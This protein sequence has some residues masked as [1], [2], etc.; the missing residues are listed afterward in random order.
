MSPDTSTISPD[1]GSMQARS[2]LAAWAGLQAGAEGPAA[3]ET[4]WLQALHAVELCQQVAE[5]AARCGCS[6]K[7]PVSALPASG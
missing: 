3:V 4:A 6:I 7:W 2:C 5:L 1:Q